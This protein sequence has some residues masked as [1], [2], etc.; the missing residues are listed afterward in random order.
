MQNGRIKDSQITT[1]SVLK[2]TAA[3]GKHARLRKN[4]TQWGAWCP[5][6][7]GGSRTERNYD[8]YIQIDLVNL[9][10]IR[11]I[12]T[13]GRE[14]A[15]GREWVEYYK[16]SYRR[17]GGV[18]NYYQGKTQTAKV[19]LIEIKCKVQECRHL[20]NIVT[21]FISINVQV[22]RSSGEASPTFGHANAN[23]SVFKSISKEMNNDNV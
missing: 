1:S 20:Q 23:F 10:I 4:I 15:A 22:P 3:Y 9:T 7:S 19:N 6:V 12:A 14:Y 21:H 18:W 5:E 17:D 13:Q 16:I 2:G 8:Q 11:A